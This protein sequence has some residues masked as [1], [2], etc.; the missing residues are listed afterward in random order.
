MAHEK[1]SRFPSLQSLL[2]ADSRA[3]A[4]TLLRS[5][6]AAVYAGILGLSAGIF[7]CYPLGVA[8]LA[9]CGSELGAVYVGLVASALFSKGQTLALAGVYTLGFAARLAMLRRRQSEKPSDLPALLASLR[10]AEGEPILVCAALSAGLAFVFGL[11]RLIEGGFLYYDLF[12]LVT[13]FFLCP[14]L[15]ALMS[16]SRI[17]S[18]EHTSDRPKLLLGREDAARLGRLVQLLALICALGGRRIFGFSP[19][20]MLALFVALGAAEAAASKP[21]KALAATLTSASAACT[22][23]FIA[24]LASGEAHSA[25]IIAGAGLAAG[26]TVGLS[27]ALEA[28]AVCI[29]A[30]TLGILELG[31]PALGSCLPDTLGAVTIWLPLASLG[32][33]AKLPS[34]APREEATAHT[35]AALEARIVETGARMTALSE[36][37]GRLSELLYSLSDKLRRPGILDLKRL[38]DDGFDVHCR[39]CPSAPI[40]LER[41][42]SSTLDVRSK[43]TTE[44]YKKGEL[45]ADSA[46]EWLRARCP[47]LGTI[48]DE[49]NSSV[50]EL[51]CQLLGGDTT[52]AFALDYAALSKLLAESVAESELDYAVDHERSKK[53]TRA[54]RCME[55]TGASAVCWGSRRLQVQISGARLTGLR[56]GAGELRRMIENTL[57]LPLTEPKFS[58]D[59]EAAVI[60]L[61]ARRRFRVESAR[62]TAP[63]EDESANGDSVAFFEGRGERHFSL[64]SDGMGSGREAAVT[65]RLCAVF[66]EQLLASGNSKSVTLGMLNGFLRKRRLECSATVDLAEIDL[67][68]GEATFVKSGAAPSFVLRSG[69]LYKLESHT[70]PIGILP[71]P[72][73]E[74]IRFTLESD[75][76]I[77]QLSD[78][79]AASL[80]DGI[81]LANL[82][83]YDWVDDLELMSEKILDSAANSGARGD[84]M[85]VVLMRVSA[86]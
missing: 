70:S 54:L 72:D 21:T 28:A 39:D 34:L 31:V 58:L 48:V 40:C 67:I 17:D 33:T 74:Q 52:E 42:A 83:V 27:R 32:L 86:I 8:F 6:G 73:A 75:D 30:L 29:T 41:E 64:I 81:W 14:A 26:L 79:V 61:G 2:D 11:W 80:E 25:V 82:L 78:G 15:T 60:T 65:S 12:G 47:R 56:L 1:L 3:L 50:S 36:A 38:C 66:C 20:Y 10:P 44:L 13:A 45:S 77:V 19:A 57:G 51:T 62:S 63:K 46:P 68:S 43:L 69:R 37:L 4:R 35:G 84:D 23:G 49:I 53:L 18:L 71:E 59:G 55:L 7:S 24:G 76:V 5:L 9:A 16:F 85:T 22:L